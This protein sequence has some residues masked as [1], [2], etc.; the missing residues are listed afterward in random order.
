MIT[1]TDWQLKYNGKSVTL[2]PSIGNWFFPCQSHYWIIKNEI[3][4]ADQWSK[5]QI[6]NGRV[7]DS[8][9]KKQYHAE[10][11]KAKKKNPFNDFM[12]FLKSLF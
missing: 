12:S 1:P 7:N 8:V 2:D 6:D 5:K 9:A 3:I 4:W 10:I 11:N